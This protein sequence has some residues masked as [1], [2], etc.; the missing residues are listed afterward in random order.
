MPQ[1]LG[2]LMAGDS[3]VSSGFLE[4]ARREVSPP[5]I[6]ERSLSLTPP[7]A[8]VARLDGHSGFVDAL[9]VLPGGR[10]ASGSWD[11]TIR[12]WDPT[13]GAKAAR[14]ASVVSL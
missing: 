12:L 1:L 13:T 11:Q 14:L 7:G 9:C 6:L 4:A 10:L 2:R 8:E 5:A 3:V